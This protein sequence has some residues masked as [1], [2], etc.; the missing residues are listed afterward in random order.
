MRDLCVSA[1][2]LA[3]PNVKLM[4][5]SYQSVL[6]RL[7]ILASTRIHSVFLC[8]LKIE[9]IQRNVAES[10]YRVDSTLASYWD[11]LGFKQI[12]K[13]V[14]ICIT[15]YSFVSLR[16]LLMSVMRG[17]LFVCSD[18]ELGFRCGRCTL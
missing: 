5:V 3:T 12:N 17:V 7:L 14:T 2:Y 15:K 1:V 8:V 18:K 10:C 9:G 6:C 4:E 11:G 16:Q 13:V